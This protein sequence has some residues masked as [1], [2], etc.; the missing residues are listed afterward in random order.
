MKPPGAIC[1]IQGDAG[2]HPVRW[3]G[4]AGQSAKSAGVTNRTRRP[5]PAESRSQAPSTVNSA[6]AA[7]G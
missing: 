3:D 5:P 2:F 7:V 4:G 1:N 6:R